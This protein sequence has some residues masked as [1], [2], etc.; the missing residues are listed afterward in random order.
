METNDSMSD[1]DES[2]SSNSSQGWRHH[3]QHSRSQGWGGQKTKK[4]RSKRHKSCQQMKLKPIP[5]MEYNSSVNSKV[6]HHFI[7]EGTMYVKDREVPSKKQA[8][9]LSHYL[10]GKTHEFYVCEISEDPYRWR[11]STF[12]HKL[13][14]YCFPVDYKIKLRKKLHMSPEQQDCP[15]L[16][17]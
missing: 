10:T 17:V 7:T 15:G 8:F 6:F 2:L 12:F 11:L 13:F 5:P 9:I 4:S 14:N 3:S 16:S 1:S